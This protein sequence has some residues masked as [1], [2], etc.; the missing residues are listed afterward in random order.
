MNEN[1][2]I[3]IN[4]MYPYLFQLFS[5][6]AK[7]CPKPRS[8]SAYHNKVN[9]M[10]GHCLMKQETGEQGGHKKLTLYYGKYFR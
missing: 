5:F 7:Y 6:T 10:Y 3:F 1:V 9:V 4:Y 2:Y 8:H